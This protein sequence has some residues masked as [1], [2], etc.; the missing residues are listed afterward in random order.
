MLGNCIRINNKT[1]V[2]IFL[3]LETKY[4]TGSQAVIMEASEGF[5]PKLHI[6]TTF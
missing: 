5:K 1:L 4:E 3:D 6:Y 2:N